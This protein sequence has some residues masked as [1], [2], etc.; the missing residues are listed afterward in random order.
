MRKIYFTA[1]N[2]AIF[3][4]IGAQADEVEKDEGVLVLTDDNFDGEIAKHEHLLVE[5]YAPWCGHCKKLAPEYAAAAKILGEKT[6]PQY[7]AKVDTTVQEKL[8]K[9][10]DIKGFPTL[11][12][13]VNGKDEE[14]TGGRTTDTIVSWIS[15]KTGPPAEKITCDD[16]DKMT[17]DAKLSAVYF[18]EESGASYDAFIA[19]AK[20]SE[21]EKFSFWSTGAE[22]ADK[23]GSSANGIAMK[24]TFDEPHLQYSGENTGAAVVEW[25]NGNSVPTLFEFGEDYIEPIFAKRNPAIILFTTEKDTKYQAA[26]AEAANNLKGKILMSY[27]GVTEGIQERLGE[28]IGVTSADLPTMRLIA[29]EANLQKYVWEGAVADLTAD[30]V[31]AFYQD[32]KDGKLVAH[33]KSEAIPET[34]DGPVKVIV[35]HEYEKIVMDETKDVF[36]KYYAPWCGHCKS[37]APKWEEIGESVKGSNLVM[38]KFDATLNEVDGVEIKGYPTLKF[39]PMDNKAGMDYGEGREVDDIKKWLSENSKAYQAHFAE[40]DDTKAEL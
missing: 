37:L 2:A 14:Y 8:G 13:F 15:K 21:A 23:L 7:V 17:A 31:A 12:W 6:P 1:L 5:F 20:D 10:F 39:Y 19:A 33:R 40:A 26:F 32:F 4:I 34:N 24:R 35:G 27:S 38:A 18:G 9:R 22:C 3:A 25:L 16:F 29:P 28:F 36:V 30:N 11:K